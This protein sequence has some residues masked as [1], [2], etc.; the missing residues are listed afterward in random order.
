MASRRTRVGLTPKGPV[1]EFADVRFTLNGT[2][3][4]GR[5]PA[6]WTL[7]R[8]LRDGLGFLGTKCGCEIGEC[9][10]CTVLFNGRAVNACLVL[11]A[12]IEGAEIWTIEGVA[13]RGS[14][15]LHPVQQ[16]FLECGAVHCGFCTPGMVLSAISLLLR[17]RRPEES[18]IKQALAGNLCRCSGYAQI[19]EAVK[20]A[21]SNVTEKDLARFRPARARS[22]Q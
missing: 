12:Q 6:G 17:E 19:V 8:Y 4:E 18:R 5:I 10:A 11:A 7:L 22:R 21:V 9:G 15:A 13:P 2:G 1:A 20:A 3:V 14:R 16:A